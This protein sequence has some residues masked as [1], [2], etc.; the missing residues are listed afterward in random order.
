MDVDQLGVLHS[1]ASGVDLSDNGQGLDAIRDVGPGGHYLG[2][3]HTQNNF[4][5]SFWKST[6]LDY[7]PFE[8]W[9]EDGENDT[10]A[11]ASQRVEYL[12][13]NYNKPE[14]DPAIDEALLN[15][16][17]KKKDSQPDKAY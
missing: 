8:T 1:I 13:D 10:V 9:A 16:I 4:R 2:C 6:L 3:E 11:L 17:R 5:D 12:L 14:L 7:K 15:F